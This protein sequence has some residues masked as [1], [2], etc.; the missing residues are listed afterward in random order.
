MSLQESAWDQTYNGLDL[1]VDP[2][3]ADEFENCRFEHCRFSETDFGR[4]R[5]TDCTFEGCDLSLADVHGVTF[6]G[7]V[8]KSC[9]LLGMHFDQCDPHGMMATFIDSVLDHAAFTA[10]KMRKTTFSGCHLHG[11][12]FTGVHHQ[13]DALQNL[14]ILNGDMQ[15]Y[16]F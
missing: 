11:V 10:R 3:P 6:N 15:I 2:W 5:F 1:S 4:R 9:K 16:Y 12:D 8:F 13:V 7:V 14:F